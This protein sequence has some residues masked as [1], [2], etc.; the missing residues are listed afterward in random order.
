MIGLILL[1]SWAVEGVAQFHDSQAAVSPG[2]STGPNWRVGIPLDSTLAFLCP[3]QRRIELVLRPERRVP[4]Q[5]WS[6][7]F[8][9][10]TAN[11]VRF[12]KKEL[13]DLSQT[14]GRFR[15]FPEIGVECTS[16]WMRVHMFRLV[17]G[18]T[19]DS[20]YVPIGQ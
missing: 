3:G 11:G 13:D 7:R 1:L 20:M 12:S 15:T 8:Q 10:G 14:P 6:K 18:R 2:V 17:E 5:G 9:S 4:G 16:K 19:V